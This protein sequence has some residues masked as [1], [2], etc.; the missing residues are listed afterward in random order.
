LTGKRVLVGVTFGQSDGMLRLQHQC[1]GVVVSAGD[2]G[3]TVLLESASSG[4]TLNLPPD[5]RSFTAASPGSYRLRS[6]GEVIEN[7]DFICD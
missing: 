4:Q 7:P 1:H 6:T 5:L 2:G 3:V